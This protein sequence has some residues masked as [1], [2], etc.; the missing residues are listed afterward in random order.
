MRV[1]S[2]ILRLAVTCLFASIAVAQQASP[3]VDK[4][5]DDLDRHYNDLRSLRAQFT[6][7]YRG[8]GIT[9]SESG[10]LWLR[11]PGKMRWE[12]TAPREKLFVSDGKTAYFYVPGERQA[13]KAPIEKLDDLRSPLRYLLGKTKLKKEFENLTVRSGDAAGTVLVRGVPKGMADRVSEMTLEVNAKGQIQRIL[14]EETDGSQT[15]FA[16][17]AIE[18]NTPVEDS[19]FRFQPP[20]GVELIESAL[21]SP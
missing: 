7:T 10:T 2:L 13:R 19:R 5:S 16:F 18:E 11:R 4:V 17:S 9:R 20:P 15:E 14:L 3:S 1:R 12:Y 8:A 21:V 6:E